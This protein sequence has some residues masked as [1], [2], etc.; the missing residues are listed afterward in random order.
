VVHP[1]TTPTHNAGS[2]GWVELGIP[3]LAAILALCEAEVHGSNRD[4][5]M[6]PVDQT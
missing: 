3:I 4:L 5:P 2:T 6:E 1:R